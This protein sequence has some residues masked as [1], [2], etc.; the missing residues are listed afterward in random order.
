MLELKNPEIQLISM[1]EE[2]FK[3][4]SL[5]L[6]GAAY[7]LVSMGK[8]DFTCD[9]RSMSLHQQDPSQWLDNSY[10]VSQSVI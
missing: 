7:G 5:N 2:P 9:F 4:T 8:A 10:F 1:D 6:C 3:K